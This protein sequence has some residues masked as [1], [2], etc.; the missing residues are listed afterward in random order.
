MIKVAHIFWW[1]HDNRVD[2]TTIEN[3]RQ[4]R[5]NID[6]TLVVIFRIKIKSFNLRNT[7]NTFFLVFFVSPTN[8]S[9]CCCIDT[10][11]ARCT[12]YCYVF[13]TCS[14][15]C[16]KVSM[17]QF[18]GKQRKLERTGFGVIL[19]LNYWSLIVLTYFPYK[20]SVEHSSDLFLFS[21]SYFVSSGYTLTKNGY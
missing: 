16:K 6:A 21:I 15:S 12:T 13:S 1:R 8:C 7:P 18:L 11:F 3:N 4:V 20:D 2:V 17:H 5:V 14:T 9:K 19:K 10:L